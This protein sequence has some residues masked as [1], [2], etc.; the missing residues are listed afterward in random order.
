MCNLYLNFQR[1]EK[2]PYSVYPNL[3]IFAFDQNEI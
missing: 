2:G 3:L 1:N